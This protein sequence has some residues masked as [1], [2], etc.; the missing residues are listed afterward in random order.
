MPSTKSRLP[1]TCLAHALIKLFPLSNDFVLT[2][3]IMRAL[4]DEVAT[5]K[6]ESTHRQ[7]VSLLLA[8]PYQI[9]SAHSLQDHLCWQPL[10]LKSSPRAC[11]AD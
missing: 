10:A 1:A 8:I 2:C 7:A 9:V 5:Q 3:M 6:I 11:W 4:H